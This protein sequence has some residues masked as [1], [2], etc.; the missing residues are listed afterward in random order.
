MSARENSRSLV[1]GAVGGTIINRRDPTSAV[2]LTA[3]VIREMDISFFQLDTTMSERGCAQLQAPSPQRTSP[4][5]AEALQIFSV[6][7]FASNHCMDFGREGFDDT[8]AALHINGIAVVGA[9]TDLCEARA[10][11][12]LEVNGV[13]VAFLAFNSILM[14]GYAAADSLP[15]CSPLRAHTAYIPLEPDQPGTPC[16]IHTFVEPGDLAILADSVSRAKSQADA[17]F[18]SIHAGIHLQPA[19]IAEYQKEAAHAA[20]DA[21]ADIVFQHHGHILKGIE[22]YQDRPIFYSMGNYVMDIHI[23][24]DQW[25]RNPVLAKLVETYH[26]PVDQFEQG[27]YTTYPFAPDARKTAI[28]KFRLGDGRVKTSLIPCYI[29]PDGAPEV[30]PRSDARSDGVLAYMRW[31][32]EEAGLNAGFAWRGDEIEVAV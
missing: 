28:A 5:T 21:G 20:I 3:P 7:S 26:I 2:A 11:V 12:V 15:G 1:I 6:A 29:R 24:V 9:G 10:P 17:V 19:A 30:V 32:T 8:I 31:A 27:E 14:P 16:R 4:R 13:R 25:R 22:V 18:V 23:P